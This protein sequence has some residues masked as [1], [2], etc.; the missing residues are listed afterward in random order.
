MKNEQ[1][2]DPNFQHKLDVVN[3]MFDAWRNLDWDKV[4]E[5]FTEDGI[6]HSMMLD[7]VKGRK[8]LN[9]WL[10]KKVIPAGFTAFDFKVLNLADSGKLLL[11]ERVNSLALN[12]RESYASPLDI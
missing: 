11:I 4:L 2:T 7:P 9:V 6:F 5:L 12:S 8:G 10:Q 1:A 3:Q